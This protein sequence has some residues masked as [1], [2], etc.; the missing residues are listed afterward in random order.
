MPHRTS[1]FAFE[2]MGLGQVFDPGFDLFAEVALFSRLE[3][4]AGVHA[5]LPSHRQISADAA[6]EGLPLTRSQPVELR[7]ALGAVGGGA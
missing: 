5:R 7:A 3:N 6:G 4:P 1:T 2:I